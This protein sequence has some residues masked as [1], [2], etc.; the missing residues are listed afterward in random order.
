MQCNLEEVKSS[1]EKYEEKNPDFRKKYRENNPEEVKASREKYE[2][3]NPDFREKY[4]ENNPEE[5]K[6]SREKYRENNPEDVK[7]SR[8]K[9]EENNPDF[10]EKYRENNPEE[11]K[12]SRERYREN[13]PME[14]KV[15]RENYREYNPEEVKDSQKKYKK[16]HPEQVIKTNKA[17]YEKNKDDKTKQIERFRHECHGPIFT[18]ICCMRDLFQRSVVG[19]KGEIKKKIL[20]ENQ[21]HEYLNFDDSLIIKDE[22]ECKLASG[23]KTLKK[24]QEGYSLCR[25][26]I[27]YLKKSQMPPMCRKN[28]LEP[29]V[30]PDCLSK[31]YSLEKELMSKNLIFMKIRQLPK[32]RMM[33]LNDRVINIPLTDDNIAKTVTSLPRNDD[34]SR[35]INIGL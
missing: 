20:Q 12:V 30:V 10:R 22:I 21:M 13:N 23:D 16:M 34:N 1:R 14:V 4:R 26:C 33:A 6:V 3:N 8:E 24:L 18:C 25:T 11:V 29:A 17:Q 27:S 32:T 31:M 19:L 5:V 35:M 9:Y 7:A 2:E 15:S 28:S